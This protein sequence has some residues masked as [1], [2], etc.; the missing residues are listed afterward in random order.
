M[1]SEATDL[2]PQGFQ[3]FTVPTVGGYT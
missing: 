3:G 1:V 2:L